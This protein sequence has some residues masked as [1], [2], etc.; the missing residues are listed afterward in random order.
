MFKSIVHAFPQ[1]QC[2][3][4]EKY[5][6]IESGPTHDPW[7]SLDCLGTFLMCI[8]EKEGKEGGGGWGQWVSM[9][10]MTPTL[11]VT[12]AHHRPYLP[13]RTLTLHTPDSSAGLHSQTWLNRILPGPHGTVN[14][15]GNRLPDRPITLGLHLGFFVI[16]LYFK[17]FIE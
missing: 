10:M 11:H 6:Q 3:K 2:R 15:Q 13:T 16:K 17:I 4:G 12:P 7:L 1:N 5:P 8:G 9:R 14:L